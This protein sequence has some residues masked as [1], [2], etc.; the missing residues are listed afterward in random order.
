MEQTENKDRHTLRIR[1]LNDALRR[2]RK[3]GMIVVTNGVAQLTPETGRAIYKAVAEF[4]A[5]NSDNDPYGEGDCAS[6]EVMGQRVIFKI[7]YYDRQR[8]A[9]SPDAADPAVT[10][11]VLTIMLADEY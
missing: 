2:G 9:H 5:F 11:R 8:Q 1:A 7:D 3:G 4:A 6:L 10:C